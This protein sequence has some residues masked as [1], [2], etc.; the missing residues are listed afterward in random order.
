MYNFWVETLKDSDDIVRSKTL[1]LRAI[2]VHTSSEYARGEIERGVIEGFHYVKTGDSFAGENVVGMG[3]RGPFTIKKKVK[4]EIPLDISV[5]PI[6]FGERLDWNPKNVRELDISADNVGSLYKMYKDIICP[7]YDRQEK[8]IRGR[9]KEHINGGTWRL[10]EGVERKKGIVRQTLLDRLSLKIN[11]GTIQ[12]RESFCNEEG[13]HVTEP[14]S[15]TRLL[16][17]YKFLIEVNS[18]PFKESGLVA[19]KV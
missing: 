15:D 3:R 5:L 4:Q 12:G 14:V 2:N 13:L 11:V 18:Q 1:H 6:L 7:I 9:I 17:M 8:I 10:L 16:E 19:T